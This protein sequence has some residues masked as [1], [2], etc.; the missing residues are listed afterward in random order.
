M[1]GAGL[2]AMNAFIWFVVLPIP[3]KLA[4][5]WFFAGL[6]TYIAAGIA[7]AVSY[8]VGKARVKSKKRR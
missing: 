1:L 3:S 8:P 6:G 4:M 2:S 7:A 5:A